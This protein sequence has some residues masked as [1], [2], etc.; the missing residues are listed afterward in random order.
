M[1]TLAR[2]HA[3]TNTNTHKDTHTQHTTQRP[4]P[5]P[6]PLGL[7]RCAAGIEDGTAFASEEECCTAVYGDKGCQV[8]ARS[9]W[10]PGSTYPD[11][12]CDKVRAPAARARGRGQRR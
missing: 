9:C 8:F 5:P 1:H 3:H 12:T 6:Q 7:A 10:V 11:R 2:T 4:L